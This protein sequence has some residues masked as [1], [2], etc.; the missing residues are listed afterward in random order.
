[1]MMINIIG[2]AQDAKA[3]FEW[4]LKGAIKEDVKCEYVVALAYLNG[5]GTE[6]K[7][8]MAVEYLL[9]AAAQVL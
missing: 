8:E 5:V 3:S 6:K 2:V 9:R 1:M 7:E 4:Y